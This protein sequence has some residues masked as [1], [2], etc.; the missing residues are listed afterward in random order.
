ME[1]GRCVCWHDRRCACYH[2]WQEHGEV[3]SCVS[4]L[5]PWLP[6]FW[7]GALTAPCVAGAGRTNQVQGRFE[8]LPLLSF[9]AHAGDCFTHANHVRLD[10]FRCDASIC[11]R[12]QQQLECLIC[13]YVAYGRAVLSFLTYTSIYTRSWS[14]PGQWFSVFWTRT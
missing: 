8:S 2:I 12:G 5:A 6:V 14:L 7:C 4:G 10:C 3:A 13:G 9:E 11:S 1:L